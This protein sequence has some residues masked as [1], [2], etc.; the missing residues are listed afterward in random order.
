MPPGPPAGGSAQAGPST[1]TCYEDLPPEICQLIDRYSMQRNLDTPAANAVPALWGLNTFLKAVHDR[2]LQASAALYRLHTAICAEAS[3]A[4]LLALDEAPRE[5]GDLYATAAW[6]AVARRCERLPMDE[7]DRLLA[8]LLDS[9]A[10]HVA[11][12]PPLWLQALRLLARRPDGTPS[13]ELTRTLLARLVAQRPAASTSNWRLALGLV[14]RVAAHGG[15]DADFFCPPGLD[16]ARRRDL[17]LMHAC[18]QLP[19]RGQDAATLQALIARIEAEASPSGRWPVL[20]MLARRW[21]PL[22]EPGHSL[23][24][25]TLRDALLRVPLADREAALRELPALASIQRRQTLLLEQA[26]ELP[27]DAAVRMLVG[28]RIDFAGDSIGRA[29]FI[30]A[31]RTL[32]R[33]ARR[34]PAMHRE[35]VHQ[36]ALAGAGT[37]DREMGVA[38]AR[39]ALSHCPRD[40]PVERVG[41]LALLPPDTLPFQH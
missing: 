15:P 7:A 13:P 23:A 27:A 21:P 35:V 19:A 37:G 28:H 38:L 26:G 22:A 24:T 17:R 2:P 41:V 30:A 11:I 4:A 31:C 20:Q 1:P 25:G 10:G 29:H 9:P 36:I 16:A 5:Y 34:D 32:A 3:D 12:T 8:R 40:T 18:G 33:E 39:L 14:G 6:K